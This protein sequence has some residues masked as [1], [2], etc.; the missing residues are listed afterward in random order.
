MR[1]VLPDRILSYHPAY[2]RVMIALAELFT[3]LRD[4]V[5][6]LRCIEVT[7]RMYGLVNHD[8]G[9]LFRI[10]S[11]LCLLKPNVRT[12]IYIGP[13]QERKRLEMVY[14]IKKRRAKPGEQ[15]PAPDVYWRQ[16][17]ARS[18]NRASDENTRIRS[19]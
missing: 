1:N 2:G 5:P 8:L 4:Q 11:K 9:V 15:M 13:M 12:F 16:L 19:E 10:M 6:A 14:D 3:D 7:D 18:L 17:R